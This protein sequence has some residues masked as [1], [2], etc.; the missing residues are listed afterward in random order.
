MEGIFASMSW[1]Y[2]M[3]THSW[4]DKRGQFEAKI[5]LYVPYIYIYKKIV[6]WK[7]QAVNHQYNDIDTYFSQPRHP[8]LSKVRLSYL[9]K[10]IKVQL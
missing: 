3:H 1:V 9:Y 8:Q 10:H 2:F 5:R 6:Y 7:Q 4:G